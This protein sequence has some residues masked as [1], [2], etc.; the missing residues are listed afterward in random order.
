MLK[1]FGQVFFTIY[2]LKAQLER[3]AFQ[4]MS[5]FCY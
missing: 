2:P 5:T 1:H 3:R 4:S